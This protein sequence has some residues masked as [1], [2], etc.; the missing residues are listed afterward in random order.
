MIAELRAIDGD[1][2]IIF[3]G[4]DGSAGWA[5]NTPSLLRGQVAASQKPVVAIFDDEG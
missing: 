2:G 5:F 4:A 1:G 3:V